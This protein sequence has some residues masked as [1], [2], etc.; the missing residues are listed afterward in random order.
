MNS[1]ARLV[2]FGIFVFLLGGLTVHCRRE[3]K[4]NYTKLK[5]Y[6]DTIKV[7]NTHEHRRRP[8]DF[9][10]TGYNFY[11]LLSHSY[12]ESDLVSAGAQP[13]RDETVN[14]HNL[15]TLWDSYGPYLNFSRGTSYYSHFVRG[16]RMLYNFSDSYFSRENIRPLSEKIAEN[17]QDYDSWFAEAFG[18]AGFETMFV[19]PYWNT[20][21]T[22]I[23]ETYFSLVFNINDLVYA[24]SERPRI[25]ENDSLAGPAPYRLAAKK[26]F[27]IRTLD[28]YLAFTDRLF[29]EFL[30]NG[31]VCLKNSMAYGRTLDYEY[32]TYERAKGLFLRE[33]STLSDAEKKIYMI[34]CFTGLSKNRS[35]SNCPFRSIPVIWPETA[36]H[37]KTVGRRSST[38]SSS[39][40]PKPRSSCFMA[41]IP[42]LGSTARSA[43]CSRTCISIWF[44]FLRFHGKQRFER[45]MRC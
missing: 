36:T 39:D 13:L 44:G 31:V 4:D 41:G 27:A 24:I 7:V 32:V 25:G 11:F 3:G 6:I 37:S 40:I 45:L 16:F 18:K 22:K 26:G 21:N 15:D 35:R 42:G 14:R 19:D 43:R 33:A 34:S 5:A 17:Y 20:F 1:R 9:D 30:D 10:V 29:Q 12:L 2:R 23:D 38:R 28:D 8:S